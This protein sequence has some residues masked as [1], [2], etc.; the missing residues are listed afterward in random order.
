[1]KRLVFVAVF[2]IIAGLVAGGVLIKPDRPDGRSLLISAAQA[3]EEAKTIYVR[4]RYNCMD[5]G[6]GPW[7]HISEG[8]YEHWYSPEG[9]RLESYGTN[10]QLEDAFVTNVREGIAWMYF[11]PAEW[12]PDGLVMTYRVGPELLAAE[13]ERSRES[14][15]DGSLGPM[16]EAESCKLTYKARPDG[17]TIVVV[18]SD[19]G[20][21][22]GSGLPRGTVEY[23][24]DGLTGRLLGLRQYGPESYGKPLTA[25][26]ELV[27]YGL[28]FPPSIFDFE[29]PVGAEVQEGS[30]DLKTD[31]GLRYHGPGYVP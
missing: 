28:K 24:I 5:A 31:G 25:E 29:P 23:E 16:Q 13:V 1:M 8:H 18:E 15:L 20:V 4:G 17:R 30:F 14:Y 26:M 19:L 9:S 6:D 10:G 22:S 11:P 2:L 7:G 12:C 3:M 21:E 27:E